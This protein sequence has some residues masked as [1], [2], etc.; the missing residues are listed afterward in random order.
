MKN[1]NLEHDLL[2]KS[3]DYLGDIIEMA[4]PDKIK[5]A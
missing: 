5:N 3:P 2:P 1:N 4:K